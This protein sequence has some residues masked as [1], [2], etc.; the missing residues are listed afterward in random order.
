VQHAEDNALKLTELE[1]ASAQQADA[2]Y[3]QNL[4]AMQQEKARQQA[5]P[6]RQ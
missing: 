5:Q 3:N 1:I 6:R 2:E 4:L